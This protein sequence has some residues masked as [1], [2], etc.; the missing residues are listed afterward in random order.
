MQLDDY[1]VCQKE[2]SVPHSNSSQSD[3]NKKL[4]QTFL[5]EYTGK[6]GEDHSSTALDPF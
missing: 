2:P 4:R 6:D 1:N 3:M 5:E